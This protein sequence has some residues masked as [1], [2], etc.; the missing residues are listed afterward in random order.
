M[1]G[2][3]TISRMLFA[4][5]WVS[6]HGQL[7]DVYEFPE[8]SLRTLVTSAWSSDLDRAIRQ[9]LDVPAVEPGLAY[10]RLCL[11]LDVPGRSHRSVP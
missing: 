11:G 8:M 2:E 9:C 10:T 3:K 7:H 1:E 5:A 6:G 4:S